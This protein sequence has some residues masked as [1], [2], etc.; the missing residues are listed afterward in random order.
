MTKLIQVAQTCRNHRRNVLQLSLKEMGMITGTYYKTLSAFEMGRS[1]NINHL[2]K[3]V[4]LGTNDEREN[5]INE[6]ATI[7]KGKIDD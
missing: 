3:Y 2:V 6:I 7:L 4:Q 1:T 5:L